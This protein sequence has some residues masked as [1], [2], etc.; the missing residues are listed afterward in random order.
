MLGPVEFHAARDPR[1]QQPHQR[2]LDDVLPV[3]EIVAVGLIAPGVDAP[4]QLRQKHQLDIFV[5]QEDGAI[6]FS[7]F[8]EGHAIGERIGI[9]APAASLIDA[10]LK[11]H[12]VR[13]RAL[14]LDRWEEPPA[15]GSSVPQRIDQDRSPDFHPETQNRPAA[16]Q[17]FCLH[18]RAHCQTR[19]VSATLVGRVRYVNRKLTSPLS[20]R[21]SISTAP[22]CGTSV[23]KL[24]R[25]VP[26][27]FFCHRSRT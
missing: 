15:A 8:L 4:A 11:K 9:Y 19:V 17:R 5:F 18:K 2:R 10:L 23:V 16:A 24:P 6:A 7:N 3:K 27:S 13:D 25:S 12:G 1:P 21:T 14:A 22:C 26:R 20:Q